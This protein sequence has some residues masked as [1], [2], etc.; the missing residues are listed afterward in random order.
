VSVC[1]WKEYWCHTVNL[2]EPE[3]QTQYLN[4][5]SR[6]DSGQVWW[7][8]MYCA[9]RTA[10][11]IMRGALEM[12]RYDQ[13]SRG[14]RADSVKSGEVTL[15]CHVAAFLPSPHLLIT[16]SP[17]LTS[18][19]A[20]IFPHD[21]LCPYTASISREGRCSFSCRPS[22]VRYGDAYDTLPLE[23]T[24]VE[25]AHGAS[26]TGR[27][28]YPAH[29]F[30]GQYPSALSRAPQVCRRRSRSICASFKARA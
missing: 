5:V 27:V 16:T 18:C 1:A 22:M 8:V 19:T 15:R 13:R 26:L 3:A 10:C 2:V 20:L 4:V 14:A 7:H 30:A 12:M 6:N 21:D 17:H 11:V 9:Q 29:H 25:T 28:R 23:N 24:I